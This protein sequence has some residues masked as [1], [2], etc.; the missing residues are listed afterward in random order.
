MQTQMQEQMRQTKAQS[1]IPAAG[2]R[3][4]TSDRPKKKEKKKATVLNLSSPFPIAGRTIHMG[5]A[6][7]AK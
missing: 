3:R 4:Q 6:R 2:R 7:Q 5:M 1:P